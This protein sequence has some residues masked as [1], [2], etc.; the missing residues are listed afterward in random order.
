MKEETIG[1]IDGDIYAFEIAA[2]AEE[3]VN[4]GDGFWTLLEITHGDD[5]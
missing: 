5:R 4:W 3:P 1:L 2:G